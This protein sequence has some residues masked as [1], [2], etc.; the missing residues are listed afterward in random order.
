MAWF[1]L[2]SKKGTQIDIDDTPVNT[3]R[4]TGVSLY[5]KFYQNQGRGNTKD[6]L[7]QIDHFVEE[8]DLDDETVRE[9]SGIAWSLT[10]Q[11]NQ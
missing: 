7:I 5:E 6:I 4:E 10:H 9:I 8:H 11:N 2:E 3:V 1:K